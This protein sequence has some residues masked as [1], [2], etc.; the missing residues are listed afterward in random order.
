MVIVG[1]DPGIGR[2]GFGV[3]DTSRDH[4]FVRCGCIETSAH[5]PVEERLAIVGRDLEQLLTETKPERAV[6]EQIFFGTNTSTAMVTAHTRGVL[7]YLLY[8]HGIELI[9]LTPGQIKSRLTGYGA[10]T[11]QQVQQ[12]VTQRL[13]LTKV[14]QPDDAADALAA[15][16]CVADLPTTRYTTHQ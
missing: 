12:M 1:L 14:P 15:A 16:L 3:I 4:W 11:K 6:V 13:Q 2:T 10:A 7:L 9:T 5:A 8:Q